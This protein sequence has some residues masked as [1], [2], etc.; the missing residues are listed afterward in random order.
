MAHFIDH[1]DVG[2]FRAVNGHSWPLL[3]RVMLLASQPMVEMIV[4]AVFLVLV[5]RRNNKLLGWMAIAI[6]VAVACSDSISSQLL[7]PWIGRLRPCYQL[8]DVVLLQPCG[9]RFGMPSSHA[10]NAFAIFGVMS[11]IWKGRWP[12]WTAFGVATVVSFSRVYLGKHFPGDVLVGAMVGWPIGLGV[13]YLVARPLGAAALRKFDGTITE[14][15]ARKG[16]ND[17]SNG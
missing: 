6:L 12:S 9:G 1:L 14:G 15:N 17:Q 13:T 16:G 3:D 7:K 5:A 4:V 11:F 2:L 8:S 10:A